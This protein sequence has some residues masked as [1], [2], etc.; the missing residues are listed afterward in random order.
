MTVHTLCTVE[1][2][3]LLEYSQTFIKLMAYT[4]CT[5]EL[6]SLLEYFQTF[7]KLTVHTP[8]TVEPNLYKVDGAQK[9]STV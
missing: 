3:S 6:K 2:K 9:C 7:I 1:L 5:V 8:C 4:P